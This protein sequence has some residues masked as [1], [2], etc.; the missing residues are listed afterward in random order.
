MSLYV[1]NPEYQQFLVDFGKRL[2]KFRLKKNYSPSAMATELGQPRNAYLNYEKGLVEPK[3]FN[4]IKICKFLGISAN[5]LLY[6]E[7]VTTKQIPQPQ[8]KE[9]VNPNPNQIQLPK[10]DLKFFKKM[11]C[12]VMVFTRSILIKTSCP[13]TEPLFAPLYTKFPLNKPKHV[14]LVVSYEQYC[15]YFSKMIKTATTAKQAWDISKFYKW[16]K[17]CLPDEFFRAKEVPLK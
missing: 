14:T 9:S 1:R 12:E 3:L 16:L 17:S 2:E 13:I 8:P 10:A 5:D 7:I 15:Q 6:D 4:V 11:Q